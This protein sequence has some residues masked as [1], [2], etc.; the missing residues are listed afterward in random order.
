LYEGD[1]KIILC[2]RLGCS[3]Y[4][5]GLL[6]SRARA[7]VYAKALAEK[8]AALDAAAAPPAGA[9]PGPHFP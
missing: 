7:L 5:S 2:R 3:P 9:T 8:K 1:V 6:V 4:T